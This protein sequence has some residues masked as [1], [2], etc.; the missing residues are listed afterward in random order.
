MAYNTK[1]FDTPRCFQPCRTSTVHWR[2][3]VWGGCW[4]L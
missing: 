3:A 2:S 4:F 1:R